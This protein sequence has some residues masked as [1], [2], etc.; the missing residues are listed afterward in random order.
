MSGRLRGIFEEGLEGNFMKDLKE[1]IRAELMVLRPRGLRE[2]MEL[3]Q[4]VKEK[5]QSEKASRSNTTRGP[6]KSTSTT[7]ALRP[8][9]RHSRGKRRRELPSERHWSSSWK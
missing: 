9:R 7:M 3:T 1:E 4:R 6:H 8:R 5:Y 2:T